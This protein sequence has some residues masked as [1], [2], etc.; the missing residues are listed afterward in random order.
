MPRLVIRRGEGTGKD[1]ALAGACV[2]GR[3]ASAQF[4]LEDPLVSRNHFR[5]LLEDGAW[6]LYDLGSRNGTVVNGARV[7]SRPLADGD[8]IVVGA[9]EL[10]FVQKDMLAAARPVAAAS[11]APPARP[12]VPPPAAKPAAAAPASQPPRRE[13][14]APIPSKKRR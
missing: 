14:Q 6:M 10:E 1:H 4:V 9:T 8:R 3:H 11:A 2:V 5:V 7:T 13:V 12:V